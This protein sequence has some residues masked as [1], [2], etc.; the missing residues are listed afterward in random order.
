MQVDWS[1][2]SQFLVLG[3]QETLGL[4][5]LVVKGVG[6][7]L[8]SLCGC[9]QITVHTK[10]NSAGNNCSYLLQCVLWAKLS[11]L[12]HIAIPF[13]EKIL[14]VNQYDLKSAMGEDTLECDCYGHQ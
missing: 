12:C 11:C 4:E 6:V 14:G 7:A 10:K 3:S 2:Q 9:N 5:C 8:T 1:D 13:T